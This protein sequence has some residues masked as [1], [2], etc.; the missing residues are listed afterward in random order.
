MG[1]AI[2]RSVLVA[3]ERR[4]ARPLE[5]VNRAGRSSRSGQSQWEAGL[6]AYMKEARNLY[7]VFVVSLPLIFDGRG[8]THGVSPAKPALLPRGRKLLINLGASLPSIAV[9]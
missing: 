7:L 4:V 9:T 3:H 5:Q 8:G 1:G 2:G 6:R